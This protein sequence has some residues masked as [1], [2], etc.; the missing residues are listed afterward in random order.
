[1]DGWD[2]VT[3]RS[4]AMLVSPQPWI[5]PGLYF[6]W[7]VNSLFQKCCCQ[8]TDLP[9]N[10]SQQLYNNMDII[11][12]GPKAILEANLRL[13]ECVGHDKW[14]WNDPLL[15]WY[16]SFWS[17]VWCSRCLRSFCN[18]NFRNP[19]IHNFNRNINLKGQVCYWRKWLEWSMPWLRSGET[20]IAIDLPLSQ[21]SS[22]S[23]ANLWLWV[24]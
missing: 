8:C 1:M 12:T 15:C 16:H 5:I 6:A 23:R 2:W 24:Y 7:V 20:S 19:A 3:G 9:E 22:H 18:S 13:L 4:I 10:S 11:L 17:A 21:P 14:Q